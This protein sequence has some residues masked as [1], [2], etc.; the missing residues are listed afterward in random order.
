MVDDLVVC[1]ACIDLPFVAT[2]AYKD[3]LFEGPV[4]LDHLA[5]PVS[6]MF[7]AGRSLTTLDIYPIDI[8]KVRKH[9]SLEQAVRGSFD[10]KSIQVLLILL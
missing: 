3:H 2:P 5:G 6:A 8:L 4:G 10:H 1:V 7:H 9:K